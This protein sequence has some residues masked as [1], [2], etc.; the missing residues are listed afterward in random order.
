VLY[1]EVRVSPSVWEHHG[2][3]VEPSFGLLV[4]AAETCDPPVR[5]IVDGVRQW[6]ED[7]LSRDLDLVQEYRDRGVVA[8]G[9]GG[10]ETAAPAR[11]FAGLA[12]ECRARRIP[13]VPHAGE[14]LGP[15][16]VREAVR[17]FGSRRIG[18]GVRASECPETMGELRDS[19]VHLELCPTSNRRTGA[20]SASDRPHPVRKFREAGVSFSLSTDDPALFRRTL[21]GEL[22]W[23]ERRLGFSGQDLLEIQVEAARAAFLPPDRR[24]DLVRRVESAGSPTRAR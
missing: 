18:H 12:G 8:L 17:V 13:I 14:V 16:E 22:A 11:A 1:A 10:D 21:T 9:L 6:S 15:G 4:R 20:V 2:L 7:R 3:G 23:A 5:L 24:A 19:G